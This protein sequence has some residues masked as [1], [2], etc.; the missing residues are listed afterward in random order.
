M[1]KIEIIHLKH[2]TKSNLRIF[3]YFQLPTRGPGSPQ[4]RGRKP[5]T[6]Q[7]N[8]KTKEKRL[9]KRQ[10]DNEENKD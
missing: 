3:K 8:I 4:R 5:Y 6:E 2:P 9:A 10:R 1:S 7:Q